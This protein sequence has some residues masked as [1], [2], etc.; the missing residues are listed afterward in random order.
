VSQEN[1]EIVREGIAAFRSRDWDTFAANLDPD[2]LLRADPR[3][4]QQRAYGREAVLAFYQGLSESVGSDVRTKEIV[5]LGDRV[6]VRLVWA[7][8]G[9][10]SGVEGEQPLSVLATFRDGR[11]ILQESFFDHADAL[12]AVGLED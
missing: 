2:T 3:S 10:L 12:K 7:I 8:R 4:P 9:Q 1:V 6:L 11:V 5:D